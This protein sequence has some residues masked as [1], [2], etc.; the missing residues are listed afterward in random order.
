MAK[1]ITVAQDGDIP[2]GKARCFQV[3]GHAIAVFNDAGRYFALDDYCP[4][5]GDSL[6]AGELWQGSV[7]CPRHM[8]AFRLEDGVC[9]DV[10]ALKATQY[11]VRLE[12]GAIQVLVP[13]STEPG[14]NHSGNS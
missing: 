9:E 10:P 14:A 6:S 8:W 7:I 13:D 3:N 11:P 5:M 12:S 4:H 1:Y 2:T